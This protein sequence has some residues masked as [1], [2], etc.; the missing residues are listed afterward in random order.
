MKKIGKK[1]NKAI[2]IL[3]A[4][5]MFFNSLMPLSVVFADEVEN[6]ADVENISGEG[7]SLT[8]G[9]VTSKLEIIPPKG[10]TVG[11]DE[12]DDKV[13]TEFTVSIDGNSII[14]KHTGALEL[15][16]ESEL[17]IA[18]TFDYVDT[19]SDNEQTT[20]TL[21]EDVRNALASE[22]GY[23]VNSVILADNIYEG[24][25]TVNAT[26][27]EEQASTDKTIAPEGEGIQ[28]KLYDA[29]GQ[30]IVPTD[31]VYAIDKENAFFTLTA[32]LLNG[33]IGPT[34]MVTIGEEE[35]AAY[36][37]FEEGEIGQETL[38]GYLYGAFNYEVT[39]DYT[40]GEQ[41]KQAKE[42]LQIMYGTYQDNTDVLNE[43]AKNV[44]LDGDYRFVG[45]S[46]NGVVYAFGEVDKDDVE[47][48]ITDAIGESEV[49][50]YVVTDDDGEL[51]ITLTDQHEVTITY[52]SPKLSEE[53][54]IKSRLELNGDSITVGDEFTVK[55]IVTLKDYA[56]NGISGLIKYDNTKLQIV[57]VTAEKFKGSQDTGTFLYLGTEDLTGK[58]EDDEV[59]GTVVV[60][61]EYTILTVIFKAL[62]AGEDTISVEDG[63]FYNGMVYYEAE[64]EPSVDVT[65]AESTAHLL[66]ALT[67]A[68][69]T[70]ELQD[71]VFEYEI[72]VDSGITKADIVTS[73]VSD[74]SSI[75]S[76]IFPEELAEGENT[77]TIEV[78]DE[79]GNKKVYT[80]KVNRAASQE[81]SNVE[82]L[83]YQQDS[84]SSENSV[85]VAAPANDDK[86]DTEEP[87]KEAKTD[88]SRIVVIVLILLVIGGLIYLIFKDEDD[89]E[90]KKANKEVDKLKKEDAPAPK[91]DPKKKNNHGLRDNKNNKKER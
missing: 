30:E 74:G 70:I 71:G 72:N 76:M 31:G 9:E 27:G 65:I 40:L 61:E 28:F 20:V 86:A 78:T 60:E 91:V 37:L 58:E 39:L 46:A 16:E 64:E 73:L 69:K 49:I 5:G 62:K 84:G 48:I 51:L 36:E 22:N 88:V 10:D 12:V 18:E 54:K 82:S 25:L 35:V 81:K 56:I 29:D 87:S 1:L 90:M 52:K 79:Y 14:V 34:S 47:A 26:I 63:K 53:A 67:V 2:K 42:T 45:D 32:R 21:T 85:E 13:Q 77:I 23:A 57:S 68:G 80:V 11:D 41:P 75:T 24:K 89:E 15:S 50:N 66:S 55:Y 43:S 4:V 33:G 6:V 8:K 83:V 7:S 59:E 3:L 17:V 19:T 38:A 44:E